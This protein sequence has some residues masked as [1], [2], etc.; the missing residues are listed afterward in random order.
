MLAPGEVVCFPCGASGIHQIL[1]R[2]ADPARVL[3]CATNDLPEVAEQPETGKLAV[4]TSDGLRLTP[5]TP[6]VVAP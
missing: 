2:A 6:T 5:S 4:L 3:I 1:N